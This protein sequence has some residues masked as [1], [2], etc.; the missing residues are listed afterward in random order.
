MDIEKIKKIIL[1]FII[2]QLPMLAKIFKIKEPEGDDEI[3]S[4][5]EA[6]ERNELESE[7]VYGEED[8]E[9]E[10]EVE[11]EEKLEEDSEEQ[12]E[13]AEEKRKKYISLGIR[14]F[15]LLAIIYIALDEMLIKDAKKSME[16]KKNQAQIQREKQAGESQ[17]QKKQVLAKKDSQDSDQGL[18]VTD[19]TNEEDLDFTEEID[20]IDSLSDISE[21]ITENIEEDYQVEDEGFNDS[22][23]DDIAL[24]SF[25]NKGYEPIAEKEQADNM[26]FNKEGYTDITKDELAEEVKKL[27]TRQSIANNPQDQEIE[28][29]SME[30]LRE[31][32]S[33]LQA[34]EATQH[35]QLLDS[36]KDLSLRG[37]KVPEV[38][39]YRYGRG[40]VFNCRDQ[41]W[42]C[43]DQQ[44]Y[45]LCEKNMRISKFRKLPS[46]CLVKEVYATEKDC[47]RAQY[48]YM[49]NDDAMRE[50]SL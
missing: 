3:E 28:G 24:T 1:K 2:N 46:L 39:F 44:A 5:E 16:D 25:D 29:V 40:L 50:C 13:G 37:E 33:Q 36:H 12:E 18:Q 19:L 20:P 7:Q 21:T 14:G 49:D 11:D 23:S 38:D 15:L 32:E 47:E 17:K 34:K 30:V 42:A 43:V 35:Q 4:S 48:Q 10:D 9:D 6:Y 27:Q 26:G 31:L 22:E 41:H 45:S 8:V